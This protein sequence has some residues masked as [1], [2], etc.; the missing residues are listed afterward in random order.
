MWQA[1]FDEGATPET[2]TSEY[3]AR[4]ARILYAD[5]PGVFAA[6]SE[7]DGFDAENA[8][9]I[10][11][12]SWWKPE[13][14]AQTLTNTFTTAS[15]IDC[16]GIAAHTLAGATVELEYNFLGLW[17]TI[18]EFVPADNSSI[19]VLFPAKQVTG[20]RVTASGTNRIGR[21][22]AGQALA[23]PRPGYTT[24]GQIDLKREA[25][26]RTY[27]SEGGQLLGKFVERRG[28]MASYQWQHIPEDWYRANFDA[29]TLS[30][31]TLPFFIAA[32]PE[33]YETD[34]AY[35]WTDE[36]IMPERMGMKNWLSVGFNARGHADV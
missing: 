19:M 1:Q 20:V 15:V 3:P 24:L 33:G 6:T 2:Y 14:N 17:T 35:A 28:L 13:A 5:T 27:I 11:T 34:V 8:Q 23:M 16:I 31:Q 9:L 36:V 4:H 12:N 32:R 30:A 18:T 10:S 21:F 7:A 22:M 29:F 26:I 25:S